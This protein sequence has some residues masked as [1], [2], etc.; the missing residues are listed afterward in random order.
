MINMINYEWLGSVSYIKLKV[1]KLLCSQT[2]RI[3]TQILK[4]APKH[5]NK[6]II[7]MKVKIDKFVLLN[8]SCNSNK[9]ITDTWAK[10]SYRLTWKIKVKKYNS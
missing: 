10:L 6:S 3:K 1:E 9:V 8:S 7:C 4:K 5:L 2:Q